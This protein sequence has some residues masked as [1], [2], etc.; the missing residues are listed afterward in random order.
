MMQIIIKSFNKESL[1]LYKKFIEKALKKI[2]Q[3]YVIINRPIEIKK[4]TLL[5][6]PHVNKSSMEQFVTKKYC[7]N[8]YIKNVIFNKNLNFLLLNK[9]K[10]I[11]FIFKF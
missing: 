9:S 7:Y 11:E 8:L 1:I 3:K 10:T 5:K 4:I 6:S 2:N